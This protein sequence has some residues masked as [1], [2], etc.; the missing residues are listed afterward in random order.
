MKCFLCNRPLVFSKNITQIKNDLHEVE[1]LSYH[2]YCRRL[3]EKRSK[4]EQEL[5][6]IEYKI[7]CKTIEEV[8]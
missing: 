4:L 3:I 6:N 7:Y 2:N 1:I 8:K 5:L